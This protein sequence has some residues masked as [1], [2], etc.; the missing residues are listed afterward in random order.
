[1]EGKTVQIVSNNN[2]ATENIFDKLSSNKYN[3]GFI[4]ATL[5]NSKNKK[6][7]IEN[8]E[9]NY[10]NFSTWRYKENPIG[11]NK[12][13]IKLQLHFFIKEVYD[14]NLTEVSNI[15]NS[16]GLSGAD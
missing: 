12:T 7:F 14:K 2:S 16:E 5:G 15:K 9:I 4:V 3:L 8:Q 10:P 11:F 6:M 1:M 13:V